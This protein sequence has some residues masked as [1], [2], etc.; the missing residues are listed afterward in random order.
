[1]AETKSLDN[2]TLSKHMIA[3]AMLTAHYIDAAIKAGMST[4]DIN[5]VLATIADQSAISEFWVSDENGRIVFTNVKGVTFTFPRDA[6]ACTQAAP[7]TALLDG[8]ETVVIQ[9]MR[10]R[11][12]DGA[13]FKYVGVAGVDKPRIV[14]VGVSAP[15][16][17]AP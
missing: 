8:V 7:F 10:E 3:E 5:A 13:L 1:M 15:E 14:Q 2:D 9:D 4:D 16:T 6:T 17:D 12:V 11:E